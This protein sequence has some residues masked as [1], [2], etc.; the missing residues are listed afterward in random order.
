[1]KALIEQLTEKPFPAYKKYIEIE[2]SGETI[3]DG[4]DATMPTIRYLI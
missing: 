1:M 2:I 4:V 3:D